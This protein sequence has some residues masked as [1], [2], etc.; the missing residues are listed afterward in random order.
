[1]AENISQAGKKSI[2][3]VDF[4]DLQGNVTELGR[5]LAEEFSV[6]LTSAGKGFEVVDRIHLKALL[7]EHKLSLSDLVNPESAKKLGQ[8]AGVEA[9]ITGS[10]TPFGDNVR[11]SVK[12]IDISTAKVIGAS[13]GNIAKTQAINELLERGIVESN[14]PFEQ[15]SSENTPSYV[16]SV[17]NSNSKKVGDLLFTVKQVKVLSKGRAEVL[18]NVVNQLDKEILIIGVY[19]INPTLSD[20]KG[21]IF[22][23][24]S[25][26]VKSS[27]YS[28]FNTNNLNFLKWDDV[29]SGALKLNVKSGIDITLSFNPE[30][31][32]IKIEDIGNY[33]SFSLP[34]Y[35]D[36]NI[37]DKNKDNIKASSVAFYDVKRHNVGQR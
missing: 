32:N 25:G 20:E 33:F 1:M 28:N 16:P 18:L 13:S 27:Q 7:R 36:S 9:I 11:L 10:I 29:L 3:V 12:I 5:F 23:Y 17:G 15:Q 6:T 26:F 22:K 31:N 34:Y 14:Q 8:I 19:E 2:A 4:T 30:D 37:K 35:I 21:N 24:V